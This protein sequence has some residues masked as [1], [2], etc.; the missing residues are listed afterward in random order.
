MHVGGDDVVTPEFFCYSFGVEADLRP[1]IGCDICVALSPGIALRNPIVFSCGICRGVIIGLLC[2]SL[3]K[4]AS[5]P[6]RGLVS[7]IPDAK[8][9]LFCG[10]VWP[11][12]CGTLT[13][14]WTSR[15]VFWESA[16]AD[17]AIDAIANAAGSL[18][19]VFCKYPEPIVPGTEGSLGGVLC[20]YPRGPCI[21]PP[22]TGLLSSIGGENSNASVV[23]VSG[24]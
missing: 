8:A 12:G 4:G 7:G 16:D 9:S 11:I 6:S 13:V 2:G 21:K 17:G 14:V 24:R 22:S 15:G 10:S 20:T 5:A 18:G 3:L 1:K 19:G 23:R